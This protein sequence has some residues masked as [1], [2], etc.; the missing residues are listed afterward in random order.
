[1]LSRDLPS[2][3]VT[4]SSGRGTFHQILST[5]CVVMGLT[6]NFHQLPSTFRAAL[7]HSFN[8]PCCRGTFRQFLSPFRAAGDFPTTSV[9]YPF[10]PSVNFRVTTRSSVN[11]CQLYVWLQDLLSTVSAAT[12]PSINHLC[13]S[14]TIRQLSVL[15]MVLPSTFHAAAGPAVNFHQLSMQP[16]EPVSTSRAPWFLPS[17]FRPTVGPFV[18]FPCGSGTVRQQ[19]TLQ[20]MVRTGR[21]HGCM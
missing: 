5:F 3:S 2:A 19:R 9:N 16:R 7:G 21:S 13:G 14:G 15:P 20:L 18:N 12:G 17:T 10:G 1:M 6:V 11:F 4:F 8:F